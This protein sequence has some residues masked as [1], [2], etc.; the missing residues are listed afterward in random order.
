MNALIIGL[1]SIGV[2]HAKTIKRLYPDIKIYALRTSKFQNNFDFIINIYSFDQI[3]FNPSFIIIS[4]PT[5]LHGET[6]ENCIKFGCPLFIEKPV[7]SKILEAEQI[8]IKLRAKDIPTYVGCNLRFHPILQYFKNNFS[9]LNPLEINIYSGSYLPEWRPNT[10]Y[11]KSYSSNK[12]KGGGVH[13]DLIH[14][15]D[16]CTWLFGFPSKIISV[17]RKLSNL[18]INSNDYVHYL[19]D[20]EKFIACITLNYFR[21]EKK[22]EFEVIYENGLVVFADLLNNNIYSKDLDLDYS[23]S[24]F[25]LQVTYDSQMTYFIENVKKNLPFENDFSI[26]LKNLKIALNEK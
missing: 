8:L 23:N 9:N 14:E 16:Y 12:L 19:L 3:S 10:D 15:I 4:N 18:E 1:G 26:G 5:F 2:R 11:K 25:E 6:I 13:L 21:K 7:T 17:K 24:N 22:R 20:F